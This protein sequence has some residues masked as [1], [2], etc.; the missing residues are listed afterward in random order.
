[1]SLALLFSLNKINMYKIHIISAFVVLFCISKSFA[2]YQSYKLSTT[3]DTV[4]IIDKKGL[5][6]GK[7]VISVGEIRGEPGYDE[8]G[9][10]KD[11]KRE[12]IWKRF[13]T[14]GDLIAIENYRY[15][16]KDGTQK[17]Y[18]FLG[19]LEREENWH[20]YN[21]LNPYDTIPVYGTGSNEIISYKIVKAV[22]YSVPDGEWRYYDINSGNVTKTERYNRGLLLKDNPDNKL[23]IN[24]EGTTQAA[25]STKKTTTNKPKEPAKTKEILDY[26]KKLS[27]KKRAKLERTGETGL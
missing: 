23:T 7:W 11:D 27:K 24:P 21:P 10:Y 13:T 16:G 26:E 9:I 5:K 20:A 17:Y 2:Q 15:G 3:G 12:G 25:D 22:Q 18:T 4:N 14:Q 19:Q 8:E 1:M 6:Q